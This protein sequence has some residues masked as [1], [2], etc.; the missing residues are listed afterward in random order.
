MGARAFQ[1]LSRIHSKSPLT[2]FLPSGSPSLS[3]AHALL[4][5]FVQ[6]P[7]PRITGAPHRSHP[8]TRILGREDAMSRIVRGEPSQVTVEA[9]LSLTD[10][11]FLIETEPTKTF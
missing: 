6:L 5:E 2:R 1:A 3:P 4:K 11:I 8:I 7:Q 10:R 9:Q